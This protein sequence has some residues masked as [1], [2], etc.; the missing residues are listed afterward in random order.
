MKPEFS[1]QTLEKSSIIKFYQNPSSWSWVVACEQTTD[2]HEANS[3]FS[4]F[5]NAP[6]NNWRHRVHTKWKIRGAS[7][8]TVLQGVNTWRFESWHYETPTH[9]FTARVGS[10]FI[11]SFSS[12][13]VVTNSCAVLFENVRVT[14]HNTRQI[15]CCRL[16][17]MQGAR[18]Y[19]RLAMTWQL[20]DTNVLELNQISSWTDWAVQHH[21]Y[22]TLQR[23]RF[24]HSDSWKPSK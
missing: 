22:L 20:A 19:R 15:N 9:Q 8:F 18:S 2:G 24:K 1:R 3:R 5:S 16:L 17:I 23:I 6:K 7:V 4:Q 12:F 21:F 10:Q 14:N 13:Y 11:N